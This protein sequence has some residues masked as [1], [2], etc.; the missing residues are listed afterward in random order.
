MN[1]AILLAVLSTL[2]VAGCVQGQ[3]PFIQTT[4]T[5]VGGSGLVITD[6]TV[7][8]TELYT[9]ASGRIMVTVANRGGAAVDI[10]DAVI[11]LTGSARRTA[12]KAIW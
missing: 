6:F 3:I 5:F 4:N 11:Y 8:P 9:D 1:K 12:S 10:G 2:F 7:D